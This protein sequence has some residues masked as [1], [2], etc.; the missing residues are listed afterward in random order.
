MDMILTAR[1]LAARLGTSVPR[2]HRAVAEGLVVPV[3]ISS[4]KA[5]IFDPD[6]ERVLRKRWGAL[7]STLSR[8]LGRPETFALAAL[9]RR[10]NG[11]R[12][13]RAVADEAGLS[14]TA[15]ARALNSLQSRGI[16]E[17][18][19]H[20]V[21]RGAVVDI[22]VWEVNW[23]SPLWQRLATS[24][25]DV[26]LPSPRRLPRSHRLTQVPGR[27]GHLF[28]DVNRESLR[29]M[30]HQEFVIRRILASDDVEAWAWLIDAYRPEE[31]RAAIA[32]ALSAIWRH[33]WLFASRSSNVF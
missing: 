21:L 13:A 31:I 26:V 5:L 20:R 3:S 18:P 19:R 22:Q 8:E 32:S 27:L 1:A 9:S 2:I 15:A 10:P 11:L 6:A 25:A 7:P 24:V 29:V 30:R 4:R 28:W 12:S 23:R 17:R 33:S 14:P 16:I